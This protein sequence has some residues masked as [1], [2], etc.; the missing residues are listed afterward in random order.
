MFPNEAEV[1][2]PPLTYIKPLF[3]QSIKGLEGG[4]VVTVK[5]SFPS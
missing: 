5:P 2:Y 1:L 4:V 3:K